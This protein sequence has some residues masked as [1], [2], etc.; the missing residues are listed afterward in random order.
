MKTLKEIGFLG[1]LIGLYILRLELSHPLLVFYY[2]GHAFFI[3]GTGLCLVG[4]VKKDK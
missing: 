3:M 1:C 2:L 4:I